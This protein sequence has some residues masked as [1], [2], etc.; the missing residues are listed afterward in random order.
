MKQIDAESYIDAV[1][2]M[3]TII[4]DKAM[5]QNYEFLIN[6]LQ[7]ANECNKWIPCSERLPEAGTPV[8]FCNHHG[9][10]TFGERNRTQGEAFIDFFTSNQ[11]FATAWMPLPE[12]YKEEGEA[13]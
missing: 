13:E 2:I 9:E 1:K 3:L 11:T 7:N 8:I 10:V 12:P 4:T 5:K 6:F